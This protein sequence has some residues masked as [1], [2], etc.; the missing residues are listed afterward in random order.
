MH[1]PGSCG[2]GCCSSAVLKR[3]NLGGWEGGCAG[4]QLWEGSRASPCPGSAAGSLWVREFGNSSSFSHDAH[5]HRVH[6]T[7]RNFVGLCMGRLP[8]SVTLG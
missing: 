2:R 1:L 6:L 8:V 4:V 3:D 5:R 7:V